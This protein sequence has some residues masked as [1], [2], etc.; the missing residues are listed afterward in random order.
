MLG[1]IMSALTTGQRQHCL[2]QSTWY[3][4]RAVAITLLRIAVS[5]PQVFKFCCYIAIPIGMTV[6]ISGSPKNL[7]NL[8]KNVRW[9][10]VTSLVVSAVVSQAL[11]LRSPSPMLPSTHA[12]Q[13]L[14]AAGLRRLPA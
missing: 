4:A 5:W 12:V 9:P 3:P 14:D 6:A 1:L 2:P 7:E 13:F 10:C 8:I 11:L